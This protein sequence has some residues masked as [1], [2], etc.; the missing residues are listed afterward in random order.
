M[1]VTPE[2]EII[3]NFSVDQQYFIATE[4]NGEWVCHQLCTIR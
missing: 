4:K 2:N 1:I 3:D